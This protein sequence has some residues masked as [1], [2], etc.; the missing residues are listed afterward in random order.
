L[1]FAFGA[2]SHHAAG[3]TKFC[4]L[5][6]STV[7]S[8]VFSFLVSPWGMMAEIIAGAIGSLVG[9]WVGWKVAQKIDQV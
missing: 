2:A 3:V 7:V 5:L 9:V 1:E 6:G 4:I 8:F